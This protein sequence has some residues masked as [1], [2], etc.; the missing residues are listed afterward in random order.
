M[1]NGKCDLNKLHVCAYCLAA[2]ESREGKQRTL[3]VNVEYDI[4]DNENVV[5]DWCGEYD[6]ILYE[7][8]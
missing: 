8:G 6:D 7:I 5:C 1:K 4:D 2:I 3:E